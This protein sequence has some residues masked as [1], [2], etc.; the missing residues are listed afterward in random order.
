MLKFGSIKVI[1]NVDFPWMV[2]GRRH[3]RQL[4]GDIMSDSP[5]SFAP[6]QEQ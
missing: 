5:G 3:Y 1:S 4:T 6:T 2:E